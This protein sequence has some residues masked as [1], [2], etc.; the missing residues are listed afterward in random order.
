M[1]K[2]DVLINKRRFMGNPNISSKIGHQCE[3]DDS[4]YHNFMTYRLMECKE[5]LLGSSQGMSVVGMDTF[6]HLK[7]A[8]GREG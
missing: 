7:M 1:D 3:N 2:G 8:V 5:I 6:K 4:R